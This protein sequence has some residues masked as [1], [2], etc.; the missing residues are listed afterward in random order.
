MGVAVVAVDHPAQVNK[1]ILANSVTVGV[2]PFRTRDNYSSLPPFSRG[3]TACASHMCD[4]LQGESHSSQASQEVVEVTEGAS[5]QLCD[6][7]ESEAEQEEEEDQASSSPKKRGSRKPAAG[8][9][10]QD[11]LR[12]LPLDSQ[13]ELDAR[14]L[15]S[16]EFDPLAAVETRFSQALPLWKSSQRPP[17]PKRVRL[18]PQEER[19]QGDQSQEGDGEEEEGSFRRPKLRNRKFLFKAFKREPDGRL[20]H[21]ETGEAAAVVIPEQLAAS[22][23]LYLWPSA[24][25]LAWYLW[26]HQEELLRGKTVLEL[27]AGTSLPGLLCAKA[28]AAKVYLA[29]VASDVNVLGNCRQAVRL[30][31]LQDKAEVVGI[32]WGAYEPDLL[33]LR[34]EGLDLIVGSDLFFDPSVFEPLCSTLSFLLRGSGARALIAVQD[35]SGDWHLGEHLD[36]WGLRGRDIRPKEFLRG[37]GIQEGDLAGRHTIFILEIVVKK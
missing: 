28:G 32:T 18:T 7:P 21:D 35:R 14:A 37:T 3:S 9:S 33:R 36:R 29:D 22:Y 24:P 6:Y 19:N 16:D 4:R 11:G 13:G 31:G 10:G 5:V 12:D 2:T 17:S 20:A 30:N 8:A 1:D 34:R 26:L 23:G 15:F 27:G 25:V